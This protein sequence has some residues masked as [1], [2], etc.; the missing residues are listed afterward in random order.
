[1]DDYFSYACAELDKALSPQSSFD[2]LR[3][4]IRFGGGQA[5]FYYIDGFVNESLITKVF[6][7][8]ACARYESAVYR[9]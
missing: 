8:V 6:E 9:A 3:R 4:V 7:Y 5:V 1:M 2:V